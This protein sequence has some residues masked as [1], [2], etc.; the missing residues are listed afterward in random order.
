MKASMKKILTFV[1]FAA[2]ASSVFA[3]WCD[4]AERAAREAAREGRYGAAAALYKVMA[5]YGCP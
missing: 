1:M 2:A 5:D 4:T 3:G